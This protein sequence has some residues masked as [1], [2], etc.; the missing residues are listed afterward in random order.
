MTEQVNKWKITFQ[1]LA[2]HAILS[3]EI[4]IKRSEAEVIHEE[5]VEIGVV[6]AKT[7]E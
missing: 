4:F 3:R 2:I 1:S 5:A 6:L 7:T